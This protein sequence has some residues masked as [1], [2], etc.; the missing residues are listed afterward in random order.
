MEND[1]LYNKIIA[2]V[3][4]MIEESGGGGGGGYTAQDI[5][6]GR[7]PSG[8]VTIVP[9]GTVGIGAMCGRKNI[10]KLTIDFS[11]TNY[12][13]TNNN[14]SIAYAPFMM[15]NI[16]VYHIISGTSAKTVQ[17]YL[18]TYNSASFMMIF[19]GEKGFNGITQSGFRGNT[20]LTTL[21][22]TYAGSGDIGGNVFYGDSNFKTLII[23]STSV[24]AL[25]NTNAFSNATAFRSGGPGGTLYVPQSLVASY[26]SASNWSTILGYTNNQIKSIESTHTDPDAPIDLTLYY[27]DGTPIPTT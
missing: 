13:F 18:A 7:E 9:D 1:V 20:G 16:P 15:N 27:A 3:A 6:M 11:E 10:T 12:W 25:S 17:G 5:L 8:E 26:Q 24:M 21:D 14:G 22:Y 19:R 4:K 23:R 2:E